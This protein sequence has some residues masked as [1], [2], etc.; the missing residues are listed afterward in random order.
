MNNNKACA[1]YFKANDV[2]KRCFQEL[3]KKW[4]A[5]GKTAGYISLKNCPEAER[6]ALG[7]ILGKVFYD[8]DIRFPFAEFEQCLQKTRFAPVDIKA[9]LELYFDKPLSTHQEQQIN[10]KS[11][12]NNFF[13]RLILY[14]EQKAGDMTVAYQ[15]LQDMREAKAYGYQL[16]IKEYNKSEA[17]AE[18]LVKNVCDGI[19]NCEEMQITGEERT[20]AI[21]AADITGNPH[22]FDRGSTAGQLLAHAI[23]YC[24]QEKIPHTAYQ[25]RSMLLH[26]GIIADTIS[27]MVH[28]YG[29]HLET[30]EGW[31]PAYEAFC[32][33]KEPCVITLE[34]M[35]SIKGVRVE[36]NC[37]YIVE[38]EMVFSYLVSAVRNKEVTI[39]CTSGQPRA[40]AVKLLQLMADCGIT[41]Y[42]SGDTDPD[43]VLIA[44]RLRNLYGNSLQIWRMGA[45]EYRK[46]VSEEAIGVLGIV[47]LENVQEPILRET[48]EAIKKQGLAGYQENIRDLLLLDIK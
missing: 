16:V 5:Y 25:W 8:V 9:V 1:D 23:S 28:A 47:K 11:K 24:F 18:K 41:M 42:Y 10:K 17:L 22:Y 32:Q 14:I 31:H 29:L 20:L 39:L 40:V 38:N 15:W 37:V 12:Q 48:A 3:W 43:G 46:S 36:N 33:R 45:K 30:D 35:N 19:L 34:N 21:F 6:R 27:S 2:Y 4:S 7:G 26:V 44:D 13:N